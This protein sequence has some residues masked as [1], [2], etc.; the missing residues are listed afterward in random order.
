MS[1]INYSTTSELI[2][3]PRTSKRYKVRA[4][5]VRGFAPSHIAL[6]LGIRYQ[7]VRNYLVGMSEWENVLSGKYRS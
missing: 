4:L 5:A 6:M 2:E 3:D 7:M 1:L